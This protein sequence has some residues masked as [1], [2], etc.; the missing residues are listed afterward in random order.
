[1][2]ESIASSALLSL[3]D[4]AMPRYASVRCG[5][6]AMAR[7]KLATVPWRE[8]DRFQPDGN[9]FGK[10]QIGAKQSREL[11]SCID[12]LAVEQNNVPKELNRHRR[13]PC[14][15]CDHPQELHRRRVAGIDGEEVD[16]ERF[17]IGQALRLERQRGFDQKRVPR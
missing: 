16:A 14:P 6:R 9:R 13:P 8:M 1:M 10:M 17:R 4:N 7:P 2:R 11:V 12:R 3:F 15:S 5:R